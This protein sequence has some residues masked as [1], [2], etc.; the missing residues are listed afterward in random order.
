MPMFERFTDEARQIVVQAQA[1]ARELGHNWIGT[2]HLLLALAGDQGAAAADVLESLGLEVDEAREQVVALVGRGDGAVGGGIPFS[3]R[4]K[5]VLELSLREALALGHNY[6]GPEHILLGLV[7]EDEG[8]AARILLEHEVTA[9]MVRDRV[10]EKLPRRPSG[11]RGFRSH[12]VG[13]S[14]RRWEY[15]IEDDPGEE[16]L[17]ELGSEGWE[18]VSAVPHGEG[19]RLFLKRP[20]QTRPA[21]EK[22]AA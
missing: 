10:L 4:A 22:P 13:R 19:V 17:N 12:F 15:R 16:H 6:I 9:D 21:E 7:R 11:W 5:K 3:P 18:L 14:P 8:V 20:A 1:E 2:E